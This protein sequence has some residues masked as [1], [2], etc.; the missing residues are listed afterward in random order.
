MLPAHGGLDDKKIESLQNYLDTLPNAMHFEHIDGFFCALICSP[1][2]VSPGEF[3]PYIFGGQMP[4]FPTQ[5]E[6]DAVMGALTEHWQHVAE[7]LDEGKPYYPF[8]FSDYDDKISGNDWA[9]AFML[10]VQLRQNDWDDLLVDVSE[11]ALL[12]EIIKLR[13]EIIE[14]PDGK[15]LTIPGDERELMIET[16]VSN[17][18]RI[19]DHYAQQREQSEPEPTH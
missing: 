14:S 5:K 16:L 18:N 9:D 17:L 8:L 2:A 15:S 12:K 11:H 1:S 4:N 7:T 6:A 13:N 3:L 19:Y 10:G